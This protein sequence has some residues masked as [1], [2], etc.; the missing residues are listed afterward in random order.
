MARPPRGFAMGAG[1]VVVRRRLAGHR[2]TPACQDRKESDRIGDIDA[3]ISAAPSA[4]I[5]ARKR[6]VAKP[7]LAER[8]AAYAASVSSEEATRALSGDA[9]YANAAT[10]AAELPV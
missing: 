6:S 8:E 10:Y 1:G 2:R 5:Y 3:D 4:L 7:T 9:W